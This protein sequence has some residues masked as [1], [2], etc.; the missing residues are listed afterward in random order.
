MFQR[1]KPKKSKL[2]IAIDDV[3]S[4]MEN[5][6]TTTEEFRKL[7]ERLKDLH[8]MKE[9][10]KPRRPSPDVVIQAATHIIGIALIIRHEQFNIITTKA[11]SF[12]PRVK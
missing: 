7:L 9:T 8:K 6:A 1:P 3:L 11:M 2:D 12:V 4:D 10:D 5:H